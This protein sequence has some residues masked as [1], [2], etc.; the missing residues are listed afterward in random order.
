MGEGPQSH[1]RGRGG[2]G[3]QGAGV[4]CAKPPFDPHHSQR[5]G[6]TAFLSVDKT[7]ASKRLRDFELRL[8]AVSLFQAPS[9]QSQTSPPQYGPQPCPL[10]VPLLLKCRTWVIWVSKRRKAALL[11]SRR[12]LT[13]KAV[14]G[15]KRREGRLVI[16]RL[17]GREVSAE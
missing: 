9:P 15:F 14:W 5:A 7:R 8:A 16:P 2:G 10:I 13:W 4:L 11:S 12:T 6:G 3:Q 1:Q 17:R